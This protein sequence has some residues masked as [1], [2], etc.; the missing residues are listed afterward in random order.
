MTKE[1]GL[2]IGEMARLFEIS[3][4]TLR[5]YDKEGLLSPSRRDGNGYRY[6]GIHDISRLI[7]I[8]FLR[9]ID[10]P[11]KEIRESI[12]DYNLQD[13][14]EFLKEKKSLVSS[15]IAELQKLER[16]IE[17]QISFIENYKTIPAEIR[18]SR[19]KDT[20]SV[21]YIKKNLNENN[22]IDEISVLRDFIRRPDLMNIPGD[23]FLSGRFGC[24]Y[25]DYIRGLFHF[26]FFY[27]SYHKSADLLLGPGQYSSF[28]HRGSDKTL[29]K[30]KIHQLEK[31][32]SRNSY[33]YEIW[34]IDE[35][36]SRK[37]NDYI[38]EYQIS[39]E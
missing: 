5:Y 4:D 26:A 39:S 37:E 31:K 20:R 18:S 9:K 10:V 16:I 34:Q 7:A 25:T 33:I 11:M 38:T 15:R 21:F 2:L 6:Y 1:K 14:F 28:L 30:E 17:K 29:L 36:H 12:D 32:K 19:R 3:I 22:S 35:Y 23:W 13:T 27:D 8:L 24:V